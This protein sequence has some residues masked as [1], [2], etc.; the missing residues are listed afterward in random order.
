MASASRTPVAVEFDLVQEQ[1][2][3][4]AQL[5]ELAQH[6]LQRKNLARIGLADDDRRVDE[7][8]RLARFVGELEGARD[9]DESVLIAEIVGVANVRLDAH[10]MGARFG[11][12]IAERSAFSRRAGAHEQRLE[13]LGL[14]GLERADDRNEPRPPNSCAESVI[15]PAHRL[16]PSSEPY[17]KMRGSVMRDR[18]TC[19]ARRQDERDRRRRTKGR[20]ATFSSAPSPGNDR[21]S[22]F[23]AR[24]ESARLALRR[25]GLP[26]RPR[27][28]TISFLLWA[29]RHAA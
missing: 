12:E 13:K 22:R 19:R 23:C 3:R 10:L 16:P 14:A 8:Q 28:L 2:A 29:P 15:L 7:R 9:V 5:L 17:G 1:K 18:T 4:Q 25:N 24:R 20:S 21:V 6:E 27:N 26:R 11:G